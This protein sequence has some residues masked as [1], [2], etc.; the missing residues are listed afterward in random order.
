MTNITPNPNLQTFNQLYGTGYQPSNMASLSAPLNAAPSAPAPN[1]NTNNQLEKTPKSDTITIAGKTIK[2]KTAIMAGLGTLAAAAAVGAAIVFG[3]RKGKV[4]AEVKA[5]TEAAEAMTQKANELVETVQKKIDSVVE[6]F[7]NGGKD[8]DGK[9]VATISD[10]ADD[11]SEKIMEEFAE[12]GSTVLRRSIFKNDVPALIEEF[13]EDGKGNVIFLSYG[14]PYE[15]HEGIEGLP[16]GSRKIAKLLLFTDGKPIEYNEG[17]EGFSSGTK[18]MAKELLIHDG[19][20]YEYHEGLEE[21]SSGTIKMGKILFLP[22]GKPD[23]YH[24][25]IKLF[26]DGSEKIAKILSFKDGK[27]VEAAE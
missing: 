16:D 23:E 12:D 11:V 14:K 22:D 2:K 18:K 7:K 8:A 15:Y 9:I 4:P 26:S 6:L 10:S 19:K 13:T 21:F 5:A 17:F 1:L 3:A 20:P 27:W 25:G 24:E